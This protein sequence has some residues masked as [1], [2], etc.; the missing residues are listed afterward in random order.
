VFFEYNHFASLLNGI[1]VPSL[2]EMREGAELGRIPRPENKLII[3]EEEE[4]EEEAGEE[5]GMVVNFS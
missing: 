4:N 1:Q 5:G 2:D 3:A